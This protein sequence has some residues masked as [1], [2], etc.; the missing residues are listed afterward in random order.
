MSGFNILKYKKDLN[1]KQKEGKNYIFDPLR[2]K[3]IVFQPEEMVRQ[4]FIQYLL[5]EL[6][7]PEKHI[8][9]ERQI[10]INRKSYRFDILI[11]NKSGKPEMIVECKSH[12]IP[13][14]DGA[15]IQASIYN[16]A[17]KAEYLCLT[18]GK[19]TLFYKIDFEQGT[20]NKVKGYKQ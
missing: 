8:A 1:I 9:V 11:F 19:N 10:T 6:K 14:N 15:A 7:I 4:L 16:I 2:H 3:Y 17:L 5:Q 12:K 20:I 13:V 18:N